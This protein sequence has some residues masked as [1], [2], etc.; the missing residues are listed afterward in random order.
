MRFRNQS[1][2]VLRYGRLLAADDCRVQVYH[3]C[4]PRAQSFLVPYVHVGRE[5]RMDL[6]HADNTGIGRP[7][8]VRQLDSTCW[9]GSCEVACLGG[10]GAEDGLVPRSMVWRK[11]L[12]QDSWV[13]MKLSLGG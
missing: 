12:R 4:S 9:L 8:N 13:K 2:V 10:I 11:G 1:P 6:R 3:K 5:R 7:N